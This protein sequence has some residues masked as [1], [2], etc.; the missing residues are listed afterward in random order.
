MVAVVHAVFLMAA[1]L[2]RSEES[3]VAP[4][5]QNSRNSHFCAPA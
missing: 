1:M 3:P 4:G 2:A 5:R